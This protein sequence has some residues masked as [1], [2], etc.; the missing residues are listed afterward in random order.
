[1]GWQKTVST[2]HVRIHVENSKLQVKF[3][4]AHILKHTSANQPYLQGWAWKLKLRVKL[5]HSVGE[6]YSGQTHAENRNLTHSFLWNVEI[7]H[8]CLPS[9]SVCAVEESANS[10]LDLISTGFLFLKL[11]HIGWISPLEYLMLWS[12]EWPELP[13]RSSFAAMVLVAMVSG[14][15]IML[16]SSSIVSSP[17][18]AIGSPFAFSGSAAIVCSSLTGMSSTRAT[19]SS[20][21]GDNPNQKI[22]VKMSCVF[23]S[24]FKA[25]IKLHKCLHFVIYE[26]V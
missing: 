11:L 12:C 3:I 26:T 6:E 1:M 24:R 8:L 17:S 9:T 15:G 23:C 22:D 13:T 20:A 18:F 2:N 5:E 10:Q 16:V 14:A 25:L 19:T 7:I 21:A 4:G